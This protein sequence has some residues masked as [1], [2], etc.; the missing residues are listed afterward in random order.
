L[1]LT[2][3]FGLL[4]LLQQTRFTA[5]GDTIMKRMD[6]MG[7]RMDELEQSL[8]VLMDQAGLEVVEGLGR[9]TQK[10]RASAAAA[11]ESSSSKADDSALPAV[12]PEAAARIGA[13]P[14]SAR[15]EI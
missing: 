6:D 3:T 13:D 15:G 8:A 1:V 12:S 4:V 5:M 14:Q 7:M 11:R 10:P 9:S 2:R